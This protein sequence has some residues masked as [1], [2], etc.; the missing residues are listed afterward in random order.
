MGLDIV[1]ERCLVELVVRADGEVVG[2]VVAMLTS[3]SEVCRRWLWL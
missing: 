1:E 3:I 2:V